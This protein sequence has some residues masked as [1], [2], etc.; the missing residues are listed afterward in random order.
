ME[1]RPEMCEEPVYTTEVIPAGCDTYGYTSFTCTSCG[2]TYRDQYT[3][4][5]HTV[6]DW[7]VLI[8]SSEEEEG[9]S[10]GSCDFCGLVQQ[11]T[12]PKLEPAPTEASEP[13]TLPETTVSL[14]QVPEKA[15]FPIVPAAAGAAVV[16]LIFVFLLC[17]RKRKKGKFEK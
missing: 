7:K 15:E 8:P 1:L 5:R 10:E 4:Y 9:L 17:P 13:P 6:T 14:P 16:I 12:D 11:R 2:Y 3:L